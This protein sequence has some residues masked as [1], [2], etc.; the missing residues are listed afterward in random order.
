LEEKLGEGGFGEVWR[1]RHR[2]T[3]DLR[4]FKF[5]FRADRLRNLKREMTIFRILKEALGERRDIERLYDVQFEEAPY[6]LELEY[7]ACGNLAE[8]IEA[9]GGFD[10]VPLE[11]RCEIIAQI[12]TALAAAHSVGVIHKDIKPTNV[13]VEE[14]KDGRPRCVLADFG[15]G[16]LTDLKALERAGITAAGFTEILDGTAKDSSLTGTRL[17][18]APELI[19]ERQPSTKSDIYSLGVL[20]YQMIVGNLSQPMTTDWEQ[21]VPDLLL[22]DDLRACLAGEPAKRL[23]GADQLA[24]RLRAMEQRRAALAEREKAERAALRRQRIGAAVALGF[25][26]AVLLAIALGYGLYREKLQRH[27]AERE[28]YHAAILAIEKS[29]EERRFD[30]ARDL[31]A[32]CPAQYR[33]WEW[34]WLQYLCNLDL[35]TMQGHTA[36]VRSVAFGGNGKFLATGSWDRTAK[37]WDL[38]TG[39]DIRTFPSSRSDEGHTAFVQS[40][41]LSPDGKYLA[42]ASQDKT[43]KVWMIE[44][45]R[46]YRTFKERN[47]SVT[48][49]AFH[50]NGRILATGS[51]D[52]TVKLWSLDS[53]TSSQTIKGY[54]GRVLAVAFSPDGQYLAAGDDQAARLWDL[55]NGREDKRLAKTRQIVCAVAFSPDGKQ[56][57]IGCEDGSAMLWNVATGVCVSEFEGHRQA[58]RAVAFSANAMYLATASDDGTAKLWDIASGREQRSFLGHSGT[59]TGIA[60]S[61]DSRCVATASDD[62]T[63]K[64]WVTEPRRDVLGPRP[65]AGSAEAVVLGSDAKVLASANYDGS[66]VLW[67]TETGRE[68]LTLRGMA[69]KASSVALSPGGK[70]LAAGF[71]DGTAHLWDAPTAQAVHSLRAHRHDVSAI[72]FSP[73]G[74]RLV[75]ASGRRFISDLPL[76]E[77]TAKVWDLRAMRQQ[78]LLLKG[79]T[80]AI[81]GA[82][83]SPDGACIATAGWDDYLIL[84]DAATGRELARLPGQG[85]GQY[86]LAFSRDGAYLAAGNESGMVEV[87]DVS[88][89]R[90][91]L[92]LKAH[93]AAVHSAAFSPDSRRLATAGSDRTAKLWDAQTGREVLTLREHSS[94]ISTV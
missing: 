18:M 66:V 46:L 43:A 70:M 53:D 36:P 10:N 7:T 29:I 11:L 35:K 85:E 76:G 37:L 79:H 88:R 21:Q 27:T 65:A 77:E 2:L 26:L 55:R 68:L 1:A 49:V 73:D 62:N 87:W 41:A 94:G 23:A 86:C 57:A 40:V 58:V 81:N 30:R 3:K 89:R 19:A 83:F 54:S 13:L 44:T 90:L 69:A 25:G 22:R 38:A 61:P 60:F 91:H 67:D 47:R 64:L 78:P 20:L 14:Q 32:S 59:V 93:T 33:H 92:S 75:T 12:A 6:Y 24:E 84:W 48:S 72:A 31:L 50:P 52:N 63:V 16:L 4:V 82:A 74:A 56:L 34:G 80:R 42:T 45:G 51:V 15:I 17:Y 5:C 39:R 71:S 9:R 8:W 28:G